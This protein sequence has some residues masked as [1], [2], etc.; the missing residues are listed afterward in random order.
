MHRQPQI[1]GINKD[2]LHPIIV[3]ELGMALRA[4]H[5][6]DLWFKDTGTEWA[7]DVP[8]GF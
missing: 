6:A 3:T 7:F 5:L 4:L 2:T 8:F 1:L